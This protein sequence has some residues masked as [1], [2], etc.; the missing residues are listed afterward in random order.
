MKTQLVGNTHLIAGSEAT[1]PA[2]VALLEREG[3]AVRNNPDVYVRSYKQFGVEEAREIRSRSS[4]RALAGRRIFIVATPTMTSEAQ[5]ALL[6]TLE[7]PAD[8][9]LFFFL[10]PSPQTLLATIRSRAQILALDEDVRLSD[11]D[12]RAFLSATPEKRLTMLAPLLEKGDDDKRDVSTILT[13]LD[14]LEREIS[15]AALLG[16]DISAIYRARR[17]LADKGAL[18]KPLLEQ[19]AFLLPVVK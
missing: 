9:A 7:E 16:Q 12:T 15:G 10:V 11:T 14:S 8:D 18:V 2:L 5:N 3:F 19:L 13:F 6:K 17:Y 4:S 1:I